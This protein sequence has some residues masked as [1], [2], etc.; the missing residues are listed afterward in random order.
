M[1][2]YRKA[3][4]ACMNLPHDLKNYRADDPFQ[5]LDE[6]SAAVAFIVLLILAGLIV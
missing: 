2:A 3:M 6:G 1:W 4:G 5:L